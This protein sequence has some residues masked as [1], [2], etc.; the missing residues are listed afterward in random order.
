VEFTFGWP[1]LPQ[2][3]AIQFALALS[4]LA[5]QLF[6]KFFIRLYYASRANTFGTTTLRSA[7]HK[8]KKN[9]ME[10]IVRA[11]TSGAI[12]IL[13]HLLT[14]ALYIATKMDLFVLKLTAN[15]KFN[16]AEKLYIKARDEAE[17]RL[18][19]EVEETMLYQREAHEVNSI[20]VRL[21]AEADDLI[22]KEKKRL[23]SIQSKLAKAPKTVL[24]LDR[25]HF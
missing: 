19:H 5:F 9:K 14:T 2:L 12:I 23:I 1:K 8:L 6:V 21:K 11:D 13:Y 7:L 22:Q 25:K 20:V 4:V 18:H 17:H 24:E 10:D 3:G 15:R 16:H